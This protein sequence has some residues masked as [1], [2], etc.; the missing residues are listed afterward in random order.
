LDQVSPFFAALDSANLCWL[1]AGRYPF[2]SRTA[3]K[4]GWSPFRIEP[5]SGE[6]AVAHA[7]KLCQASGLQFYQ[8]V[9]ERWCDI[10][11][12]SSWLIHAL[13]T[14][15][16]IESA[17]IDSIE[18]LGRLY[19]RELTSGMIGKW[20]AARL[21]Q[22]V[23]DRGGRVMV[24]EYLA[25]L[26]RSG[27]SSASVSSLA[28]QVWDGLIA[29]EWAEETLAGPRILLDAI[30]RDWLSLVT[31][32]AGASERAQSRMLQ[33]FM[34]RAEQRRERPETT[35]FSSVIRQRLLDL[36]QSGFPESFAWTGQEIRIPKIVAVSP[37]ITATAELFWC[38][39]FYE[40]SAGV[41]ESEV[42][43]LI[44]VCDKPLADAQ[45]QKWQRQLETEAR[46]VPSASA[47]ASS[48]APHPRQELWV[49]VPP[50]TTLTPAAFRTAILVAGILPDLGANGPRRSCVK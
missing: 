9:W 4:A 21:D 34:F 10:S 48:Q 23:P 22:A 11:G 1:L 27:V 40:D 12:T 30:Q 13:I 26:A 14:A 5:F 47:A 42:I 8:E 39:G 6:D 19:V 38:Y 18:N 3:G 20:L 46:L 33:A 28:P 35:R 37:E 31:A 44:T 24:G 29:E 2:V 7:R 16:A 36:P 49:V 41:P 32:A 50:E 45:L 15:A 25:E 43:L 17:P